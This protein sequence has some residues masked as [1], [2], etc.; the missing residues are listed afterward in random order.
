SLGALR[1]RGGLPCKIEDAFTPEPAILQATDILFDAWAMTTI[2]ENI[3]GR[4]P[5]APYLHGVAEWEP[6]RTSVAWR[7]EVEVIVNEEGDSG[8]QPRDL[9]DRYEP[10]ELLDDYPLKPHELLSDTT[11][12]VC[13]ALEI[14]NDRFKGDC[15]LW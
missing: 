8:G 4:P 10:E 15:P 9:L 6:P 3:P 11:E 12:R 5:V 1:G 2:R 7:R 13:R 14:L